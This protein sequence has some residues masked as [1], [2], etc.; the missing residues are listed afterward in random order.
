MWD[1]KIIFQASV[2]TL[3]SITTP[4]SNLLQSISEKKSEFSKV[5]QK[6]KIICLSNQKINASEF[7]TNYRHPI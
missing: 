1:K 6:S 4:D 7:Y 3:K 5:A 2:K